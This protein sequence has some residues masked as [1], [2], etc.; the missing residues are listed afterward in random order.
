VP[1]V[2]C[3]QYL[4]FFR[5]GGNR[6][7]PAAQIDKNGRLVRFIIRFGRCK[8]VFAMAVTY[9]A[10]TP[11]EKLALVRDACCVLRSAPHYHRALNAVN[12]ERRCRKF[13]TC[14]SNSELATI[15]TTYSEKL[16]W[17]CNES[18]VIFSTRNLLNQHIERKRPRRLVAHLPVHALLL[19]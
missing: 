14:I 8:D 12:E 10:L 7:L 4:P 17:V 19:R 2:S 9:G 15:I 1:I 11:C 13:Q 3:H 5:D 18:G 16:S 6:I